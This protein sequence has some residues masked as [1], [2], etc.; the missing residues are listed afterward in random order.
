MA[1]YKTGQRGLLMDFLRRNPDRQFTAREIAA[2]LPAAEISLSAI[3]RNLAALESA[4]LISRFAREG[5]REASYQ[6]T[7]AEQCRNCLHMICTRCGRAFHAEP[8]TADRLQAALSAGG[9]WLD[10]GKTVLYGL[11]GD[12]RK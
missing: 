10:R 4:G 6:Y 12:C 5:S 3:Y 11:C 9:F 1:E 8:E 2:Q 7:Q